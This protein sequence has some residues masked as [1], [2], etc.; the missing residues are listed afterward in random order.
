MATTE[1]ETEAMGIVPMPELM[2]V[3]RFEAAG[4]RA[5]PAGSVHYDGAWAIRLTNG[6]PAKRL[7]SVNPLDPGDTSDIEAR[8]E[9]ASWR[10]GAAGRPLTMRLSPLAASAISDHLDRL[11]W[12]RFDE[13]L[14]MRLPLSEAAVDEAMDQIP[15]KDVG[16]FVGA[17][18]AVRGQDAAL[19]QGL[20]GVIEAVEPEAG[21]FVLEQDNKPLATAVC[22]HDGDL[23]GLFEIA[24]AAAERGK[25]HGRRIVLSALKWARLRGAHTAWLQVEAGNAPARKLY[26]SIG[27]R[28]LYRYHYRQPSEAQ[29]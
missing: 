5:W 12:S 20:A 21:L 18:V 26:E 28:E 10:F 3:R 22:V 29:S 2:T 23:A 9:R 14:V 27:F 4:F 17:A 15:M 16:R 13:S 1:A 19:G 11:H 8:L 6:H 25:G 24:T 7:N